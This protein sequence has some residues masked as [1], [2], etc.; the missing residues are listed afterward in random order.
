MA[1][2]LLVVTGSVAFTA[3]ARAGC[4]ERGF[5]AELIF[6]KAEYKPGEEVTGRVI[7]TSHYPAMLPTTINVKIHK[8]NR[9]IDQL[10]TTIAQVYPGWTEMTLRPFGLTRLNQGPKSMGQWRIVLAREA[11]GEILSEAGFT[12]ITDDPGPITV[13]P[14]FKIE[15]YALD[16]PNAR[17]MTISTRG[18][19]FVGT[20]TAGK[21]YAVIDT[22]KDYR[23]ERVITI[24]S[25]LNSPNGVAFFHGD[26][27]VAEIDRILKYPDIETR[28]DDPPRPVVV[29]DTF[30]RDRGHG[31]KYIAVGPDGLLYVPVGAPCN[32][33]EREDDERYASIMRMRLDGSRLEVFAR[34]V[35]NTVG[36]DWHPLKRDLWFTDN[37]RDMMGDDLPPDEL[38]RAGEKGL[39]FGF[40]YC[41]GG[42]IPDPQF[43][44]EKHSCQ[45]YT[46]PVKKL[47]PHVAALGM[48]FYTG[49]M[50]PN[51]YKNQILIA[52]HGSWNRSEP[53]GY[54]VMRVTLDGNRIV[55]YEP[56][57]EGW[58]QGAKIFGRPV[59][60]IQ[61]D[62]GS[63]LISDDYRGTI[64]R[65]SYR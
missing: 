38:N 57:A 35:R 47:G 23:A 2:I 29:N 17:S 62:D 25:G 9:L 39:H 30:P 5:C 31:W 24:A 6:D 58:L 32:V 33:C 26:L 65:V 41:H 8:D 12:V 63:I 59:D 16:V 48:I 19:L 3:D 60:I 15:T 7:L 46:A 34:G 27:Y 10:R 21:V 45:E 53:I 44:D 64:L 54:R 11:S 42:D 40:P 52:E 18:T 28:L 1:I 55:S 43:G 13:P 4:M 56:F 14:G 20:R 51:E 36:F 50:F 61:M 37:G 22:N 49:R